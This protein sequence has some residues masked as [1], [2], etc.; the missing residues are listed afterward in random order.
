VQL[1]PE[2]NTE[3]RSAICL[4]FQLLLGQDLLFFN[5]VAVGRIIDGVGSA[6]HSTVCEIKAEND[7][8]IVPFAVT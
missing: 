8:D 6:G 2:K 7:L 5:S 3:T 4:P 1:P